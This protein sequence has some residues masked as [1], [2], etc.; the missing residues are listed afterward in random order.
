MSMNGDDRLTGL[1]RSYGPV[2]FARCRAILADDASA[3][4][5]TQE[6]FVRVHRHLA[7]APGETEALFWIYRIA[8]NL[9]FNEIRRRRRRPVVPAAARPVDPALAVAPS[10]AA[11]LPADDEGRILDRDLLNRLLDSLSARVRPAV[12]L[13]HV[14]GFQQD[15]VARILGVS[16]RTVATWLG[17]ATEAARRFAR[18]NGT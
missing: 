10:P 15:E 9:C 17:E 2:I 7:R 5:T 11:P 16:R 14:D 6:T 3:E 1:Y 8:T 12:W 18:R 13:Y 4:D